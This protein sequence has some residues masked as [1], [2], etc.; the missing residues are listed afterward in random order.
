MADDDALPPDDE[1]EPDEPVESPDGP[2][3]KSPSDDATPT[4]DDVSE[5][6][7]IDEN[8]DDEPEV[9]ARGTPDG[10]QRE[11]RLSRQ[12]E[13]DRAVDRAV[14]RRISQIQPRGA[15]PAEQR[16]QL[17]ARRKQEL[18]EARMQGP[19]AY[20]DVRD[21]H[22]REDYQ[23]DTRAREIRD[24]DDRNALRF[25]RVCDR[26]PLVNSVR[27]EVEAE[28]QRLKAQGVPSPDREIVADVI[29]GRRYRERAGRSISKQR[30]QASETVQR[31]TVRAPSNLSGQQPA[32]RR[33]GAR[34]FAELS[35]EEMERQIGNL[36]VR[37]TS[38]S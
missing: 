7:D 25:E 22:L 33:R 10:R 35:L 34:N 23:A 15:D 1:L 27:R 37:G 36:P 6:T 11:R 18:D 38:T 14:E 19:E 29:L 31:Q 4:A 20:A 32:Q 5:P 21:R 13:F 2:D 28:I 30:R 12:E 16:R 9:A 8:P 17:E 24:A 3:N 26:D